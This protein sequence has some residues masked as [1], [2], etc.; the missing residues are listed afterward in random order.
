MGGRSWFLW[1][2]LERE[3]RGWDV[4]RDS[5]REAPW[6]KGLRGSGA[7]TPAGAGERCWGRVPSSDPAT[8]S[9]GW[10]TETLAHVCWNVSV[11]PYLLTS[12]SPQ[13]LNPLAWLFITL[14]PLL[15]AHRTTHY[16]H[17]PLSQALS[18]SASW[19]CQPYLRPPH[20][21]PLHVLVTGFT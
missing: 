18:I 17:S 12:G 8:P 9:M 21:E 4:R 5:S 2:L 6:S 7:E 1:P 15:T 10:R 13:P 14:L 19:S 20:S 3:R 16:P 11:P